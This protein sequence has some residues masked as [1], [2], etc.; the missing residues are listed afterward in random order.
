MRTRFKVGATAL[1]AGILFN[2][3]ETWYFGWNLKPSCPAEAVCD[4]I[5]GVA[6]V[7]GMLIVTYC[8]LFKGEE[9]EV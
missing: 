8:N 9:D 5:A 2:F 3:I 4:Y 7:S 6:M 1:I